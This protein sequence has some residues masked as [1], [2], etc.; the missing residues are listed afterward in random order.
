MANS[1]YDAI[2]GDSLPLVKLRCVSRRDLNPPGKFAPVS[3]ATFFNNSDDPSI[4]GVQFS[5]LQ[6]KCD[7]NITQLRLKVNNNLN[8][9]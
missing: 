1:R 2:T 4:D 3:L 5:L 6:F 7:F 8:R 9:V